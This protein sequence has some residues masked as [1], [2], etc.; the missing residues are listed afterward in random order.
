MLSQIGSLGGKPNPSSDMQ[1]LRP[2]G[3]YVLKVEGSALAANCPDFNITALS[4]PGVNLPGDTEPNNVVRMGW[5]IAPGGGREDA[6][7]A[8]LAVEFEQHYLLGGALPAGFEWHLALIDTTGTQHRPITGWFSKDGTAANTGLLLQASY[9]GIH[10]YDGTQRIKIFN[11]QN[12]VTVASPILAWEFGQNNVAVHKQLNAAGD[13]YLNLPYYDGDNRMRFGGPGAMTGSV[14]G[15]GTY[16]TIFFAVQPT[17]PASDS[18]VLKL[19]GGTVTGNILGLDVSGAET[20]NLSTRVYNTNISSGTAHAFGEFRVG[21]ASAGDPYVTFIV[22]SAAYW[23]VGVDN[24]DTD[25]FV[26]AFKSASSVAF[27]TDNKLKLDTSGNI[28]TTGYIDAT[29]ISA[30][31]APAANGARIYAE[32]NGSGKTRLMVRFA[33]GAAQQIAIEP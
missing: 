17:S 12:K 18:T 31:A 29:E 21:G 28:T 6:T 33:S 13:A 4:F 20:G 11:A 24:S 26:W 16:P 8:S 3:G 23:N 7:K 1:A 2:V 5:N 22:P 19:Y 9:V 15:S 32:D 14:P 25:A 27:G 30:P 10:D